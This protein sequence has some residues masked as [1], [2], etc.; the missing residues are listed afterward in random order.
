M[1][2]DEILAKKEEVSSDPSKM[3]DLKRFGELFTVELQE[4]FDDWSDENPINESEETCSF[5]FAR[6]F[7]SETGCR[8]EDQNW[9]TVLRHIRSLNRFG[10]YRLA[11]LRMHAAKF[12]AGFGNEAQPAIEP[13]TC[14]LQDEDGR[15]RVWAAATLFRIDGENQAHLSLIAESLRDNTDEVRSEAAGALWSLG[16]KARRITPELTAASR[17]HLDGTEPNSMAIFALAKVGRG[18]SQVLTVLREFTKSSSQEHQQD[19]QDAI[20]EWSG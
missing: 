6:E 18:D 15:V 16:T 2:N 13:L 12:L 4:L 11:S 14:A 3:A 9:N 19:I 17:R 5:Y 7:L 10:S 8:Q 1:G 20:E